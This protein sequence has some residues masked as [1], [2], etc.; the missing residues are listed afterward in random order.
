MDKDHLPDKPQPPRLADKATV[1]ELPFRSSVPILGPLIVW[2]RSAW[3][4]VATKWYV[5]PMLQQQNEFNVA[6]ADRLDFAETFTYDQAA[7][8]DRDMTVL[9][10]ESAALELTVR[11]L[12]QQVQDLNARLALLEEGLAGRAAQDGQDDG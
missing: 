4:S 9:H 11:H 2:V 1:V 8:Q 10:R 6:V 5:R 7:R 3:N 12:E